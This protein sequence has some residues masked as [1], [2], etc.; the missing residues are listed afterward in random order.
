MKIGLTYDLRSEYLAQ[1]Y[2]EE[3]TAEFDRDDTITALE[4]T[5]TGLGHQVFKIGNIKS[6]ILQLAVGESWDLVFNISEGLYGN[7]RESQVPALLDAWKIPYTFS[8]PLVLALCLDK[9]VCKKYLTTFDIPTPRFALLEKASQIKALDLTYPVFAKPVSEGTGKGITVESVIYGTRELLARYKSLYSQ[10]GQPLLV[11]EFLPGREFTVAVLGQ[12]SGARVL[13]SM[14]I[15]VKDSCQNSVYGYF[16][17]ENCETEIS[18]QVS[19]DFV[20]RQAEKIALEA[21]RALH[22]K[23]VGRIDLKCDI[24]GNPQFIEINPIP[25]L[26]PEHSDLPMIAQHQGISYRTLI[27]KIITSARKRYKLKFKQEAA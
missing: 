7:A 3:Q 5:L 8:D 17:K 12:G 18:Y 19:S 4:N 11:E 24:N 10:Y 13:G 14:E 22:C 26:H 15:L 21:Y 2:S 20:T 9:Y 1:G 23:D 25:G 27:S 16:T 6:L